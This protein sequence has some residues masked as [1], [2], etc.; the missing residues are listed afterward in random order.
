MNLEKPIGQA[1]G[2]N[3]GAEIIGVVNDFHYGSL[4][5]NIS[6]G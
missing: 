2:L 1:I 6:I 3:D 4:R 5:N